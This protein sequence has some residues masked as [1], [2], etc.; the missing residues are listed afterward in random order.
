M[1]AAVVWSDAIFHYNYCPSKLQVLPALL[2]DY[3]RG[4]RRVYPRALGL[5]TEGVDDTGVSVEQGNLI[6]DLQV[7]AGRKYTQVRAS[8]LP[9]PVAPNSTVLWGK[10]TTN[11]PWLIYVRSRRAVELLIGGGWPL[12]LFTAAVPELLSQ[13]LGIL[14]S[15]FTQEEYC[16]LRRGNSWLWAACAEHETSRSSDGSG[17]CRCSCEVGSFRL[18]RPGRMVLRATQLAAPGREGCHRRTQTTVLPGFQPLRSTLSRG[19]QQAPG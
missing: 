19:M 11:R 1:Q 10:G 8:S 5:F 18:A 7:E 16:V 15:A 12:E 13:P 9:I 17:C 6:V 4:I 3:D 14:P 2:K